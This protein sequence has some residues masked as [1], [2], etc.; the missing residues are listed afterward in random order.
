VATQGHA[1]KRFFN[2]RLKH[3]RLGVHHQTQNVAARS[4]YV[5]K[6]DNAAKKR[7]SSSKSGA[8]LSRHLFLQQLRDVIR[9]A[10][11]QRRF[12]LN[13]SIFAAK[14]LAHDRA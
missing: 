1:G 6:R 9:F 3:A 13:F 8:F 14:V 5:M 12:R 4:I 11:A 7:I 2:R 10:S